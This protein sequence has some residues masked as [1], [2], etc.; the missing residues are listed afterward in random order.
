MNNRANAPSSN[1][2]TY[3]PIKPALGQRAAILTLPENFNLHS[4]VFAVVIGWSF[5]A[6]Q[7]SERA[8]ENRDRP[9]VRRDT[10]HK[11]TAVIAAFP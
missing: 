10:D 2:S 9:T 11:R 8:P 1:A 6:A 7:I 3:A 4:R 5:V